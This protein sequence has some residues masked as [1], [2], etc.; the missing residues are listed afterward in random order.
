MKIYSNRVDDTHASSH[1]ILESLSRN[2]AHHDSE[3]PEGD[4]EAEVKPVSKVGSKTASVRLNMEYMI[5]KHVENIN[6]VAVERCQC[7]DPTFHKMSLAFDEGG[8][9]GML[10]NNMVS[11]P[12]HAFI[13]NII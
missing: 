9:R 6:Q 11:F 13:T 1:R 2:E 3:D 5:E 4:L 8:A 12:I 10:M 7:V